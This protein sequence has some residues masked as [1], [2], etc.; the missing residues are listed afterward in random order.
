MHPELLK[1]ACHG[2][3]AE[4]ANLLT[5]G[6]VDDPSEVVVV[7]I[8][9]SPASSLLLGGVTPDGD[10]ALHIVAA[11]GS[12]TKARTIYDRAAGLL[13]ARNGGGNTPLHRAAR[14]GHADMVALLVQL[15]RGEEIAGEDAGRAESLVRM[16]NKLGEAALHEA[17]RAGDM[18]TVDELM[19]ADPGLA[20]VPDNGTSPLFLAVSLRHEKIARELYR[21]DKDLSYSG[22]NGQNALHAAVLRSRGTLLNFQLISSI[23]PKRPKYS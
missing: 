20:R 11:Y 9:R 22:P 4:L 7:Q 1:A 15:A 3:C 16:Q 8:D 5:G 18:I 14:A 21:R 2:S 19:T 12:L 6:A 13:D 10:S 23:M 17:I